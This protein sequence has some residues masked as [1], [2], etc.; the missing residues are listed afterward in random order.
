[1]KR[2]FEKVSK[3]VRDGFASMER[4]KKDNGVAIDPIILKVNEEET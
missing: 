2:P 1:L 3:D 4:A